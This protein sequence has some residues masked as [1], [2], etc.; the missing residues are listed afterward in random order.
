MGTLLLSPAT[1]IKFPWRQLGPSAACESLAQ[2]VRHL[3]TW[4]FATSPVGRERRSQRVAYTSFG[5]VAGSYSPSVADGFWLLLK[6]LPPGSH[7]LDLAAVVEIEGEV[8]FEAEINYEIEV[9]G[10]KKPTAAVESLVD[11]GS[12]PLLQKTL[13]DSAGSA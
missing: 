6:P 13:C 2:P 9:V 7:T 10:G 4:Y 8:V 5:L 11:S 12:V 1:A 3:C